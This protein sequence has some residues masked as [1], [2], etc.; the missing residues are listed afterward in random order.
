MANI[1]PLALILPEDVILA[2]V[3]LVVIPNVLLSSTLLASSPTN[4]TSDITASSLDI[5][6]YAVIVPLALIFPEAV[7]CVFEIKL[8]PLTNPNAP[9]A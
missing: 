6:C 5:N 8:L 4:K 9:T 2:A 3:P 7:I 1:V